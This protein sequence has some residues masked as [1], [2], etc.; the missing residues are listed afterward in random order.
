MRALRVYRLFKASRI[1]CKARYKLVNGILPKGLILHNL[2]IFK[3]K[4]RMQYRMLKR[5]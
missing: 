4:Y 3:I 2:L 1:D 5:L